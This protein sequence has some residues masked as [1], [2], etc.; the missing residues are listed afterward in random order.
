[1]PAAGTRGSLLV[2]AYHFPP[3]GGVTAIRM[4]KV[5]KHLARQGWAP[6]V[7]S[8]GGVGYHAQDPGLIRELPEGLVVARPPECSLRPLLG[9]LRR[10][11]L[12]EAGLREVERLGSLPDPQAAWI[13]GAVVRGLS[14]ART[15]RPR[16]VYATGAPWSALVA[17]AAI[18]RAAGIPYVPHF[19]D[20]WTR[21]P[22]YAPA[23]GLHDAVNTGLERW[24]LEGAAAVSVP[25]RYLADRF[26]ERHPGLPEARFLEVPNGYDEEDFTGLPSPEPGRFTLVHA[27][28]LDMSVADPRP[29]L[30]ALARFLAEAPSRRAALRVRLLGFTERAFLE[31][32]RDLGLGDCV[33]AEGSLPHREALEACASADVLLHLRKAFDGVAGVLHAKTMEYLR[34]GRPVLALMPPEALSAGVLARAGHARVDWDDEAGILRELRAHHAAWEAGTL[35]PRPADPGLLAPCERARTTALLAARLDQVAA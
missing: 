29:F 18:G 4:A 14:M 34:T 5:V 24:I 35:T 26:R 13:P 21:H 7:L 23:S 10:L 31:A 28:S 3:T 30:R 8:A 11:G 17:A 2:V 32:I 9:L 22:W 27:G 6:A 1:M 12:G 19:A 20:E 16:A 15:L 33:K 25:A